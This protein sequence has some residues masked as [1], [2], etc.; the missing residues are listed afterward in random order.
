VVLFIDAGAEFTSEGN[1]NKLTGANIVRVLGL[2]R[3]GDL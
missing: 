2:V 3:T 1:K